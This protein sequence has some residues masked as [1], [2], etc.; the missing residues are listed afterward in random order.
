MRFDWLLQLLLNLFWLFQG[1]G[2]FCKPV[3]CTAKKLL[4]ALACNSAF[5]YDYD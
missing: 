5:Y 3:F 2:L 4:Q 1:C